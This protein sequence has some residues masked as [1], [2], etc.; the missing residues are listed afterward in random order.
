MHEAEVKLSAIHLGGRKTVLYY[1][2]LKLVLQETCVRSF[3]T[4]IA[5]YAA[6]RKMSADSRKMSLI[7]M[8]SAN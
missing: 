1:V 6:F 3:C 8:K 7:F 5:K 4:F 2:I